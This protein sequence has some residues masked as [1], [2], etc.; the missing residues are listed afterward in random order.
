[1]VKHQVRWNII[2]LYITIPLLVATALIQSTVLSH[3]SILGVK[4]ELMLMVV[5]SWSLLRGPGEGMVWAFIG[6]MGL[7]LFSG[8][9]FGTMTVALL[10][11][12]FISGLGEST[13]FRTYIALPLVTAFVTTVIYDLVILVILALTGWPVTWADSVIHV[14]LPSAIANTLLVP[15]VFWP[16]QWLHRKAGREEMHW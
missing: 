15:L 6:G 14:V 3:I 12:S 13:V 2:S 16:L 1:V 8:A 11:V 4:P 5:I 7:D 10:V 9:P